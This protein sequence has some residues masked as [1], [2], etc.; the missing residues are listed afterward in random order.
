MQL[1]G[2]NIEILK[3]IV[4]EYL[5]TGD[6]IGS[7]LLLKKYNLGVSSATVRSDMAKLEALDLVFQPYTS[8]G[9]LPTSK[10]LRAFVNYL[11]EQTPSYFLQEKNI[12]T[13]NGGIN[14]L[15]DFVFKITS[16]LSKNTG[17]IA[18]FCIPE[19]SIMQ[20]CGIS[21]FLKKNQKRLG[22]DIYNIIDMLED[23]FNFMRFISDFPINPGVNVFIGEENILPY[24]KDYSII[25]KPIKIDSEIG[26]IGI[27]GSL[28]MNYSF[29]ISAINGI[30]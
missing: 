21:Q 6:V 16:T 28:Q 19:K 17:E 7:K 22:E 10:G 2:R 4:E 24:L 11:M 29:N 14:K 3:I 27:I 18:F 25:I 20:H 8:A 1:T 12:D 23:K 30:I 9:R 13:H 26:Y 5:E 15:A